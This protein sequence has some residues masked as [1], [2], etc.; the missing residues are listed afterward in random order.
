MNRSMKS[1]RKHKSHPIGP[2][3]IIT[4]QKTLH[5]IGVIHS[6]HSSIK[7]GVGESKDI[8][9]FNLLIMEYIS[10]HI[11]TF[12]TTSTITLFAKT[13]VKTFAKTFAADEAPRV[14]RSADKIAKI[15]KIAK[16]L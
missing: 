13:Y 16:T 10:D 5:Q 4:K 6:N 7:S 3:Y 2:V 9:N 14:A 12:I 1:T 8:T 15:V 11:K